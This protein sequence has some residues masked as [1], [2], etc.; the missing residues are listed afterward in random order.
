[1]NTVHDPQDAGPHDG[2]VPADPEAG[3]PRRGE[4]EE[5]R[6]TP[7]VNVINIL[8]KTVFLL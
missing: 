4:A 7:G 3:Q 1:M 5:S 8:T 2:R 6:S